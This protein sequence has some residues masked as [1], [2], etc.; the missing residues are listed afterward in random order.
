MTDSRPYDVLNVYNDLNQVE[1]QSIL[2]GELDTGI[3]IGSFVI[4][5]S[6]F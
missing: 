1:N 3:N 6:N 4:D 2:T 5:T